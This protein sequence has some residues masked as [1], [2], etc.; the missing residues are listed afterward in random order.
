MAKHHY[1]VLTISMYNQH[2]Q[3]LSLAIPLWVLAMD[4]ADARKETLEF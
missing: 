2:H 4:K 3:Q 1:V